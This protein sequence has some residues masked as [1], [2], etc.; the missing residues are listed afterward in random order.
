MKKKSRM[1]AGPVDWR[2]RPDLTPPDKIRATRHH[3][4]CDR[5]LCHPDCPTRKKRREDS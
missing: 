2:G 5:D 1:V 3:R 4:M